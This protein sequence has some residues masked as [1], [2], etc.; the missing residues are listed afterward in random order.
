MPPASLL[1]SL[2]LLAPSTPS[3]VR[4]LWVVRTG[5]VSPGAVDQ[6]V[7]QASEG[8]LNTLFVQVRGRGDAFYASR[9]VGRSVLLQGQPPTFDPFARLLEE[10]HARGLSVH[11]WVNVLLVADFLPLPSGHVVLAHPQWL[12]VPKGAA[13]SAQTVAPEAL[14]FLVRQA[15][16]G[17]T[18]VEGFYLSPSAP[19]VPEYLEGVVR[20]LVHSYPVDGIH[21]D[22]I[23]YPN[24]GYDF[25]PP[26]VEG[27]R[28]ER[29]DALA[30]A[31]SS[32]APY[33]D[34]LRGRLTTL[35]ERLSRAARAERPGILVSAA[36]V[37]DAAT[38][39]SQRFQD[40]PVW[41]ARDLLD[42]VCPMAYTPEARIFRSQVS[43]ARARVSA[44][45]A[46]WA[47]VGAYRLSL[48]AIVDRVRVA[49]D[50][51]ASGIILF[52]HESLA[53]SQW[54]LLRQEAFPAAPP[55]AGNAARPPRAQP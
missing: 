7:A 54:K 49:R 31:L 42:A 44:V 45:Q 37:P 33:G 38:A 50:L 48:A 12:M 3:E 32:P 11:A 13:R 22:F 36:V 46:V 47:G 43:E 40:W 8:G 2:V 9:L 24:P 23:R 20:E 6:V 17:D 18:D 28:L 10:A 26:A 53:P 52:S 55:G 25:S 51:G 39:V 1:L 29:G 21:L 30:A 34:Y 41:L 16:R 35:T 14:P 19:G 4:G 5:L 15:S 27:F